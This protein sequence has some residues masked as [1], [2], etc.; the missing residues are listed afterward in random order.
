MP[1]VTRVLFVGENV[2]PVSLLIVP[3]NSAGNAEIS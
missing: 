1:S 3:V 2:L